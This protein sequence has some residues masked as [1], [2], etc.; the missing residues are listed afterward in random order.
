MW[1]SQLGK[2]KYPGLYC[3][4]VCTVYD[5]GRKRTAICMLCGRQFSYYPSMR[6]PRT[7]GRKC[8]ARGNADERARKARLYTRAWS[9]RRRQVIARDGGRCRRCLEIP[10]ALI[11]HHIV[12]WKL[13]QDDSMENLISLCRPCHAIVEGFSEGSGQ[14]YCLAS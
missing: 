14:G 5:R 13:T 4:K 6:N 9:E 10:D 7:C 12:A 11:V 3:S 8:L 1:R 2:P